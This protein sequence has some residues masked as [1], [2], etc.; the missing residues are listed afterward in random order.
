MPK[1]EADPARIYDLADFHECVPGS[2]GS[3][4]ATVVATALRPAGRVHPDA[5][6]G[7]TVARATAY[8]KEWESVEE[9]G[10]N[11]AA[12]RHAA[13][14]VKDFALGD[15]DAIHILREWN[16]VNVPPLLSQRISSTNANFEFTVVTDAGPVG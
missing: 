3:P 9:G 2:D 4:E 12:V 10:R 16:S 5:D 14:L 6:P 11:Q 1:R 15:E 13:A 8:A 7:D